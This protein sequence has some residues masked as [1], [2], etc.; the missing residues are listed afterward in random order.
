MQQK[1]FASP[2]FFPFKN[3]LLK[4]KSVL[5]IKRKRNF[6]RAVLNFTKEE[7]KKVMYSRTSLIRT[8]WDR[9][10]LGLFEISIKI[11]AKKSA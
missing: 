4:L 2:I 1:K 11:E 8:N 9:H 6:A 5:L 10:L 7:E 3:L